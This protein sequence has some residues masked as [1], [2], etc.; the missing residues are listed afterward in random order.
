MLNLDAVNPDYPIPD[1]LYDGQEVFAPYDGSRC[2][3][4]KVIN[5][6]GDSGRV[7]N[8]SYNFDKW[9]SRYHLR[10]KRQSN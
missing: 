9:F 8:D 3:R 2:I 5:A 7:S 6:C 1:Y 4:C 10:I